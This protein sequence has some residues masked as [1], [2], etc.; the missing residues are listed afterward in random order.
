MGIGDDV[1]TL[2]RARQL[3][4]KTGRALCPRNRQGQSTAHRPVYQQSPYINR[5]GDTISEYPEGKR[6]YEGETR[7]QPPRPEFHLTPEQEAWGQAQAEHPYIILNPDAKP[8]AHHSNNK[9]WHQPYWQELIELLRQQYPRYRLV[10]ANPGK[11]TTP[12]DLEDIATPGVYDLIT[13]IKYAS[14]VVTTEGA[15][16]HIAAG[17]DTPCTVIYG[18]CTSPMTTGYH[19]QQALYSPAG[20]CNSRQHCDICRAEMLKIT[21]E[22]VLA[23]IQL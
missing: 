13:L 8:N 10:R 11:F 5:D 2:A 19:G 7:Y 21:P 6:P 16:H 17:T 14:W 22:K 18:H 23:T 4:L 15:P 1:I 12:Y 9:H 20:P 3:Y